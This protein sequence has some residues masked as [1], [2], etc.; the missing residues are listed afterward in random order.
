MH[1]SGVFRVIGQERGLAGTT[2]KPIKP[3][4]HIM[5]LSR[6]IS[7]LPLAMFAAGAMAQDTSPPTVFSHSLSDVV[8]KSSGGVTT[9]QVRVTFNEPMDPASAAELSHY[10][11]AGSTVT[12]ASLKANG[13]NLVL[14]V[15]T[16]PAAGASY[17]LTLSGVLDVAGNALA[18]TPLSGTVAFYEVNWALTG[19]ATQSS[20]QL[21]GGGAELAIDGN[22]DGF[23]SNGSV[24]LNGVAEDA[25]WLEVD[26]GGMKPIGKLH[27]WFR[28][29]SA[30]ECQDLFNA[31]GVRNDDFTLSVLDDNR[32]VVWTRK[33]PGRPPLNVTYNLPPG[34]SGRF[35]RFEAQS[36]RTSSDGF[37]SLAELQVIEPYSGVSIT[38]N[39]QPTPK[40]VEEN[41]S[42]IFGPVSAT[43]T[44]APADRIQY[45]WQVDGTDIPG[46]N[47][48]TYQTPTRA[49]INNGEVYR[50]VILAPGVAVNSADA[51]LTVTGDHTPPTVKSITGSSSL[52]YVTVVFSEAVLRITVEEPF[53]S[54]FVDNLL[55]ISERT[56]LSPT[57]LLLTT[58]LQTPG[59]TY[60]L[61]INNVTDIAAQPNVIAETQVSFKAA[62]S[63]ADRWVTIAN[64]GNPMDQD[65][66]T[67]ARGS[68][69]YEYQIGKYEVNNTEYA[70]FLNAKAKADPN[71]LWD[72]GMHITREGEPGSYIYTV[73]AGWEK[74]P[75]YFTATVDAYRY[76]N[77][78]NN[79]GLD[80]SDTETGAYTLT[81]YDTVSARN[82]NADYFLPSEN[83][84]YK[85]AY[86]DPTKDGTGGYWLYPNRTSTATLLHYGAP[87]DQYSLCF[88]P[89]TGPGA[90]DVCDEDISPEASSYYGT[91]NQAGSVWEWNELA[92]G[93]NSGSRPRRSGGSWGNNEARI[94][95]SVRA[96]NAIGNGG[97]SINQGFRVA[98][99][100]R[101]RT[102]F[103]TVGNS[104]NP[105]DQDYG[106]GARGSVNYAYQMGKY[107]VNNTEYAAFLNAKAKADPNSLWDGGMHITRGG[108]D[109]SYTYTVQAGWEKR[110][111]YFTATVDAYR[112]ANW[113]NNGGTEASDTETGS[114]TLTGYD[115]VS[116]RSPN[117][118]IVLPNEN[119]WYKAAYYDPTKGGTGGYWL[120]PNRTSTASLLHYGAPF[121]QFSLCFLPTTGPGA[122]D[123]CDEDISPEA[124]SYY[125]TYNQ[126]GS[127]WEWNELASGGN[128]GSRPRRSGGSWGNNEARIAASVRADNAIGNGGSSINQ[129]FR[130]AQVPPGL[131]L[132]LTRSSGFAQ[133]SWTGTGV[134]ESSPNVNGPWNAVE[135]VTGN[136]HVV[137]LNVGN[138]LFFRIKQ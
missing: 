28:T 71:S 54:Y 19:T 125:G 115:T 86:Y 105:M 117:A 36:P 111:V 67:G 57:T 61:F 136:L 103:V 7:L 138:A 42:A 119:E 94:A 62:A 23:Y 15:E 108:E 88:L 40:S 6:A 4:N 49:L 11:F 50:C 10:T 114:Y 22:V 79:G 55:D 69:N 44:G 93:G 102:T 124:S 2:V 101:P 34:V 128:S 80:Y 35:V 64:P 60:T 78:L 82:P 87:F 121:D 104:G 8:S 63:E 20:S 81:G 26:L 39:T 33:Y 129:G 110:P 74:R 75:V 53:N 127:V 66:G 30:Q 73:Q 95:A 98:R 123:V 59:E 1:A 21:V 112:Y 38:V 131:A 46:A 133:I 130:I 99:V 137:P 41:R 51:A 3:I 65:Y 109:G 122:S 45:Q 76:A 83:E 12:A 48:T 106:T 96:D 31:C 27:P 56:V 68:V 29:L 24:T 13:T 134:L 5:K 89:A 126:A 132:T 37:F 118:R 120:Y 25:G 91:Y 113:L 107:E 52:T 84:W 92:T 100:V 97:S 58:S 85:A 70:A 9:L 43:L 77:W 18:T 72:G 47:G 16:P 17:S 14:M 135:G 90:S 32:S 116:A